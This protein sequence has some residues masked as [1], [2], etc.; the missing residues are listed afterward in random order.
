MKSPINKLLIGP[1]VCLVSFLSCSGFSSAAVTMNDYCVVP[2]F[3]QQTL[4]PLLMLNVG[5]DHKL[6]YQAYNDAADLDGDGKLDIEYTHT[7]DYYGYFDSNKCYTYDTGAKRF[8]PAAA[9]SNKFC[10]SSQWSGNALNW[11]TMTRMDAL[12]KVLYGGHRET[13]T[14]TDTV[15]RRVYVPND[16]HSWGKELTGKLCSNGTIYKQNCA[17]NSDCDGGYTCTDTSASG[18]YLVP[19]ATATNPTT[20]TA[21]AV[22]AEKTGKVLVARYKHASSKNCGMADSAALVDSYEPGSLFSAPSLVNYVDGFDDASLNPSIHH[23]ADD[24]I[25]AVTSFTADV[26]GT[27]RFAVDGDDDVEVQ[28]GPYGVA[29]GGTVVAQYLGCHGGSVDTSHNGS[30]A[31]VAG[32]K[33]TIVARHFEKG[34]NDGVR[35]WFQKPSDTVWKYVNSTN[36]A[37]SAPDIVT[38]NECSIMSKPFIQ[39]GIPQVGAAVTIGTTYKRH[40]FCSTTAGSATYTDEPIL[41]VLT[42]RSERVWSWSAKER[43]LCDNSLGTPTDYSVRVKVCDSSLP[44]ANCKAYGS[45]LKPTGLLHKYGEGDGTKACSKNLSKTCATAI[46]DSSDCGTDEGVCIYKSPIFFGM[47]SGSYIDNTQ[48]GVLRKNITSMQE[49]ISPTNG[50]FTGTAGIIKT[51]ENFR[52]DTFS[53][54]TYDCGW[55]TDG[56]IANG[57]C[58]DW[59][60]PM[61]EIFYESLRYFSGKGEATSAY[62]TGISDGNDNGLDLPLPAWG[63]KK[64][65]VT[66]QPYD[67]YP[68]CSRPF[69]LIL[70]D[71]NTSYDSNS[72]PGTAFATVAEDSKTPQ[73]NLAATPAT[74]TGLSGNTL[75]QAV[76]K[77]IGLTE[78]M[79]TTSTGKDWFVGE[80]ST[81]NNGNLCTAKTVTD[82]SLVSGMCPEEPTKLGTYYLSGLAYYGNTLLNSNASIPNMST[83]SVA[84]ASPVADL[85]VKVG[86]NFVTIAPTAKS[87]SGCLSVH[88][89]CAA[90][91]TL[92]YDSTGRGLVIPS[93]TTAFCPTN[94]IVNFFVDD[95]RYDG[96]DV[97]YA[98]FRINYED[99]EQGA[100]HD[101]D[102]IVKYELCTQTAQTNN[103]GACKNTSTNPQPDL[104]STQF[105]IKLLSEYA[106]GCIDQVIGFN[107]S[108][109][110]V[111]TD[112]TYLL[113]K[114]KD[115]GNTSSVVDGMP[116]YAS[117]VF[118]ASGGASGFLKNPLWYAAKWGGFADAP[119]STAT[120]PYAP[121]PDIAGEWAKNCPYIKSVSPSDASYPGLLA[122]CDPDNYYLVT[123][124]L[125]LEQQ[126]DSAL[127]AILKTVSSGTAASILNNSEGS[128][129][130]LLQAVFYPKKEY[131]ND[132]TSL[133]V[134]EVQNLW[135]YLDP[136]LQKTSIREDSNQNNYLNLKLDKIAQFNFVPSA[137]KTQ[138]YRFDD[139]NGDGS[140]DTT[141]TSDVID[142]DFTRSLW[143]AGQML[144][145]RDL[146][147]TPYRTLYTGYGAS[148]GSTPTDFNST[149]FNSTAA[150]DSL[151]VPTQAKADTL[152]NWIYGTDQPADTDG[153]TYRSRKVDIKAC[154]NNKQLR[155]AVDTDCTFGASTGTCTKYTSEWRLGDIVNSTPKLVSNNR[156][157]SY[158]LPPTQGYNDTSYD[159]FIKS[160]TYKY[161]GMAF[162]GANDGMLHAFKLGVLKELDTAFDKA[163]LQ[164]CTSLGVCTDATLSSNLGMEMW[165]FIPKHALPYLKYLADPAYPHLYYVDRTPTIVDASINKP[166]GCAAGDDYSVCVKNTSSWSTIL[167]GGAGLGG[168]AKSTTDSCTSPAACVKAPVTDIGYSSYFALDVTEPTAPKYLW[169]FSG[170]SGSTDLGYATTGP[171]I[172]RIAVKDV[173]GNPVNTKNGKWFAVF[174]SGPTGPIDTTLHQFK[175]QSDQNL[176][177]FVVDMASGTL[178]RTIDTG[179]TNAFAGSLST[180]VIDTDRSSTSSKGF[181]SDDALYIG[182]TEKDTSTNTWTKGGVLRLLTKENV[183]PSQWAV[184][185]LIDG[186]GPVTT[187]ISKSQ[188]RRN[189]NLWLFFGT[190]RY[191]FKADDSLST[192]QQSLYG[193]KE[194]CY[195]SFNRT[196]QTPKAGG[197]DNDLD[198]TCT[199]AAIS[200]VTSLCTGL[201]SSICNQSGDASTA[202]SETLPK[203]MSGWVIN[204]DQSVSASSLSSERVITDPI[205]SPSGAVFFTTFKPSSDICKYG[206]DTLVWAAK[207]DS[208]GIPPSAAM[209]G[210]A[211]L[212]VSTGAFKEISLADAFTGSG[213]KRLDGRRIKDPITG[214][215][216]TGQGLSLITNPLPV[217][218]FMHIREK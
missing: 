15:L 18:K 46:T 91:T 102:A 103:Y 62:S 188:D 117:R 31:L 146:T 167:I 61:G 43:P 22:T 120:P 29:S 68:I 172:V 42:D 215:P 158:N 40:L 144:W 174:A 165:S 14:A 109:T 114:D 182:Y 7:I 128:G 139:A 85:K 148:L 166:A 52:I 39:D 161:R 108:G 64:G 160:S 30:I 97:V 142:P 63:F 213:S 179:L 157:N 24:N 83:Y 32:N 131:D 137:N 129:A 67:I 13:D 156:L 189:N 81:G 90:K 119:P 183:D 11:M 98:N 2:P 176:K 19:F 151:Q 58:K 191:F 113:I 123:N 87:V 77:Q 118:E 60:N 9:A 25:L 69:S 199:D 153:T 190:G 127:R 195:S 121:V 36:L 115:A 201:S 74:T 55:K 48:G 82:L 212:Q 17:I 88:D 192:S 86:G 44:E 75:L 72:I 34:G 116:L 47:M 171:A 4:P 205:A 211:L 132:T 147:A 124:P 197:T 28:V 138:V 206:G 193:I 152:I 21:S 130:N 26:T 12:R 170:T 168:A 50:T 159:S 149:T 173:S 194:P 92:T 204:L 198:P 79:Y 216:P 23:Y 70:S 96:T 112:G 122:K 104:T 93:S 3:I 20:C 208:G 134:G 180:A 56:A 164:D 66:Y 59:G 94:Q 203:T 6:Y 140:S 169:E 10:S 155:C 187:S 57:Q 143:K 135:Y 27:W 154:S 200:S 177:L 54:G 37:L 8:N 175:G 186:I 53:G 84:L 185:K 107:I 99:V 16:A 141:S 217:K 181:Y 207:Y 78:G 45:S 51:F 196:M 80:V 5:R 202:P 106:A 65:G 33:Y 95:V 76:T 71:I 209:Q 89:N 133:W 101:M 136:N 214:V 110:G 145:A 73:L 38:G 218:K 41:R 35:V 100:D 49:E 126:L 163:K 105:Q 210:K 111:T 184:S 150:W 1:A 125:Y 178:I 162:V